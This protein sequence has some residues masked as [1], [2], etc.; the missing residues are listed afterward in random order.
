MIMSSLGSGGSA[1]FL[2][3]TLKDWASIGSGFYGMYK[4]NQQSKMAQ[5]AINASAPW[6]ASG[7]TA[8]AGDELKR[9]ISGDLSGDPGF[10]LAQA[11]AARASSQQP[12]GFASMAAANAALNYRMQMM[13]A[14]SGPAGVGFNPAA[15]YQ[16]ALG[17]QQLA[18]T[19]AGQSLGS[20]GYG[21]S[22]NS[23]PPWLQAY[24]AQH[25]MGG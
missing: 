21:L 19:L 17:G 7:G 9:T 10:K 5:Q 14:L 8:M 22:G 12:G 3:S 13:Q 24:L 2:P 1:S 16:T 4:S 23:I 11:A 20:I 25:G 18:N 15:G 6:T